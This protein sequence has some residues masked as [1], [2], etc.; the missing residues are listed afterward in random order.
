MAG[1]GLAHA[2]LYRVGSGAG[3][4]AQAGEW[5][6]RARLVADL[7]V[8]HENRAARPNQ[9]ASLSLL[10]FALITPWADA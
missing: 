10:A 5:L 8:A 7:L 4:R 6:L 1:V 2:T 9:T 3:R